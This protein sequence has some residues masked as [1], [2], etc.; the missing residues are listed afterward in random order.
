[1]RLRSSVATKRPE[2]GSDD[3]E[4]REGVYEFVEPGEGLVPFPCPTGSIQQCS[5]YDEEVDQIRKAILQQ[6]KADAQPEKDGDRPGA[7]PHF[8]DHS[9]K[10][11]AI[12]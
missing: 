6:Q 9:T 11:R 8:W 10:S 12:T 4:G 2:N 5:T 7:A 1:M 3:G